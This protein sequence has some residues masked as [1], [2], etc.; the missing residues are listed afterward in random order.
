MLKIKIRNTVCVYEYSYV[1]LTPDLLK[2]SLLSPLC[3]KSCTHAEMIPAKSS[4][5][6]MYFW[7][8]TLLS[9][10][11]VWVRNYTFIWVHAEHLH[12]FKRTGNLGALQMLPFIADSI[13]MH[14]IIHIYAGVHT[15]MW[16]THV[17]MCTYTNCTC[18]KRM[19]TKTWI[20]AWTVGHGQCMDCG[21][22]ARC[23][24]DRAILAI[25]GYIRHVPNNA[26]TARHPRRVWRCDTDSAND[27]SP[28]PE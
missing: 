18:K 15:C 4:R 26:L 1:K 14:V 12:V 2:K 9:C 17:G 7:R 6:P 11:C 8:P 13:R 28:Q 10:K 24:S 19:C 3:S 27:R 21:A 22:G 5:R 16:S 23:L 25:K 20:G